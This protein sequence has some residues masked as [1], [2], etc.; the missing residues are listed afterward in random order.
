MLHTVM[1]CVS[2]V[3]TGWPQGNVNELPACQVQAPPASQ[4]IEAP[5]LGLHANIRV[6]NLS[7]NAIGE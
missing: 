6:L 3:F 2:K 4:A 7:S 5:V 1:A